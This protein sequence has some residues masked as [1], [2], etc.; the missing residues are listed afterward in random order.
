MEWFDD[1]CRNTI[2]EKNKARQIFLQKGTRLSLEKYKHTRE[3]ANKAIKKKE[4]LKNKMREIEEL[5]KSNESRRLYQAA[6]VMITGFQ[7]RV[8]MCKDKEG[9]IIVEE[10]KIMER[11]AEYFDELLNKTRCDGL[12]NGKDKNYTERED[13]INP[14][15]VEEV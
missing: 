15:T 14:P 4:Y 2:E 7:P 9:K 1:E 13:E 3:S 10:R 8:I 11:R 12:D 6:R 5:N